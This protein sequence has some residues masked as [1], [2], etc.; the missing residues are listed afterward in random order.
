MKDTNYRVVASDCFIDV[1]SDTVER[2]MEIAHKVDPRAEILGARR[3]FENDHKVHYVVIN[4]NI[5]GFLWGDTGK[6]GILCSRDPAVSDNDGWM[7][8]TGRRFRPACVVDFRK[9]RVSIGCNYLIYSPNEAA[10]SDGAGFWNNKSGFTDLENAQVFSDDER[11][12]GHLPTSTG[13]DARF[14]VVEA[15]LPDESASKKERINVL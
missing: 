5:L 14:S 7:F 10:I 13:N 11:I 2:A 3:M 9:F 8:T 6:A 1:L 4:E 15:F 12:A